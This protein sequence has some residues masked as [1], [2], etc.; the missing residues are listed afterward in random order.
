MAKKM[1][2]CEQEEMV[3]ELLCG[4]ETMDEDEWEGKYNLLSPEYQERVY[5]GT[6]QFANDAIGS[7]MWRSDW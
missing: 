6:L 4:I 5:E 3:V 2:K 1:R 7:D